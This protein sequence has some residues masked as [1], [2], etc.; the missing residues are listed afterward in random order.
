MQREKRLVKAS[1]LY[2]TF[3]FII[4]LVINDNG[5]AIGLSVIIG[6]ALLV[7]ILRPEKTEK[8]TEKGKK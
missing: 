3:L 8:G 2:I 7:Y 5:L 6:F 4:T 1:F